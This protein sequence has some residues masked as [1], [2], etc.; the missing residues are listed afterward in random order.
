M[1]YVL[2]VYDYAYKHGKKPR[3]SVEGQDVGTLVE[4]AVK[5][6]ALTP[7]Q[8]IDVRGSLGLGVVGRWRGCRA[9]LHLVKEAEA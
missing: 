5:S 4:D 2:Q 6:W 8:G 9:E 7:Q 1:C 3:W